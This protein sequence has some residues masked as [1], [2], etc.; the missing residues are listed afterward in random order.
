MGIAV[1]GSVQD[2]GYR[3][4][5]GGLDDDAASA[6]PG[7]VIEAARQSLATLAGVVDRGD[8]AQAAFYG[9]AQQAFAQ[10]MQTTAVIAALILLLAAV[11]A[12]RHVPAGGEDSADPNEER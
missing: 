12:W 10:A 4:H 6:L 1:L 2:V 5:L 8:A 7:S 9:R 3:A 11:M